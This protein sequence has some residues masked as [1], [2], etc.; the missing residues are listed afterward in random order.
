VNLDAIIAR[1]IGA[2]LHAEL[3]GA[4][5]RIADKVIARLEE[6]Q[7]TRYIGQAQLAEM[8]G[9]SA[10]AMSAYLGR[11]S[12]KALL[13]IALDLDGRRVWRLADVE[14]LLTQKADARPRLTVAR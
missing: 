11:E 12:G 13:S 7:A 1:I 5:D 14:A 6:K 4:E 2:A 8:F 3:A 9:K 10:K